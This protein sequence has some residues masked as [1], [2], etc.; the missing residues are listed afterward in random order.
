MQLGSHCV[1]HHWTI[2]KERETQKHGRSGAFRRC[3]PQ[4]ERRSNLEF[5]LNERKPA[6][7]TRSTT[8]VIA[9]TGKTGRRV[10][11]RLEAQGHPV[12]RGSRS[13]SVPFDWNDSSTWG[14]ALEGVKAAY[15]VYSPDLAV[16]AAPEAITAFTELARDKGVQRLVLLSGRGEEEAQRCERIVQASGLEW[17]VVRASWFAQNFDE[18]AFADLVRAGEVAL[19]AG[20]VREPFIDIDDLAEIVVAALTEDRHVGQVYEVTGPRSMTFAEAVAEI[21]S[22][23]ER[24]VRFTTITR[25]EFQHGLRQAG[26]PQDAI[27]L[28]DYLFST[29]LDGRNEGVQDGVQRAL[30]RPARDFRD[31]ARKAAQSGLWGL[32]PSLA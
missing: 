23:L 7:N 9:A 27:E 15:V 21:G 3:S 29:V 20:N 1:Q 28:L 12:R 19:P 5:N 31:Y 4:S 13:A 10:A 16:P 17:T 25:E 30:G 18:G 8:L 24:D 14:A 22:A 32:H 2:S 26:L 11:D 6:M